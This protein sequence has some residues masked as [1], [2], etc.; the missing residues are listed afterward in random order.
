MIRQLFYCFLIAA[1][2]LETGCCRIRQLDQPQLPDQVRGWQEMR[3][4]NSIFINELILRTGESLD[5][6]EFGLRLTGIEH[7]PCKS[8]LSI[9]DSD[10][11]IQLQF[12][13]A[14]NN[15][16]ICETPIISGG[17]WTMDAIPSCNSRLPIDGLVIYKINSKDKWIH[18]A[19]FRNVNEHTISAREHNDRGNML[20]ERGDLNGAIA[21]FDQAIAIDPNQPFYYF[22]R[23][24][25]RKDKRELDLAISDYESALALDGT[26]SE[27]YNNRGVAQQMKGDFDA[28]IS[29]FNQ[30]LVL[31][32]KHPNAYNNRGYLRQQRG[33]VDGALSDYERAI[34]LNPDDA[35][36]YSNR[37][38]IRRMKGDLDGAMNDIAK[39]IALDP[40]NAEAYCNLGLVHL[41]KGN[42]AEGNLNLD[43]CYLR[44]PELRSKFE[45]LA[46]ET[47]R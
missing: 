9:E 19:L 23:G 20:H 36:F 41:S 11:K 24:N 15:Q 28:A 22:N 27:V 16:V 7:P 44:D 14:S 8:P 6:G 30:A 12:Y 10:P 42:T 45:K 37:G 32:P 5:N 46:R 47:K 18:I 35:Y 3:S 25:A 17:L 33:D 26:I 2:M 40:K 43:K 39:S 31:N 38:S 1:L 21:E 13:N 4:G 34:E 29:D